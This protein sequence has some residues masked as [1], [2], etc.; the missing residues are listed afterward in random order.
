M[1]RA[2]DDP[3]PPTFD[4]FMVPVGGQLVVAGSPSAAPASGED[5]STSAARLDLDTGE[6]TA[7]PASPGRGYQLLGTD[8]GPLL[9]GHFT[10]SPGWLVDRDTWTWSELPEQ[11]GEHTDLSGVL[12][13]DRATYDIPDGVGQ[14]ASA[15]RLV[16][17]DSAAD[18]FVTI[19]P[20][21]DRE[22]VHDD[23]SAALGRDL[24][25]YGGQRWTGDG[26]D[27]EGELVGDAWLWSAPA[28]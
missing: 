28:S 14:T 11:R 17:Y 1:D 26:V 7:L 16:V 3:L 25:V 24:F 19:P 20:L 21:P 27:G 22:D 9:N 10:D 12:D 4:R 23:S 8:R 6:W 13:R 15:T 18:A 5:A 2:P